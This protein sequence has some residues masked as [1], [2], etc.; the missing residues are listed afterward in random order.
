MH[1]IIYLINILIH[2]IILLF[3]LGPSM[4]LVPECGEECVNIKALI[5]ILFIL[6]N[7]SFFLYANNIKNYKFYFQ[8]I[9]CILGNFF[10]YLLLII[11]INV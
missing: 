3:F 9:L 2:S 10:I 4:N 5:G 1:I 11:I 8:I 6:L 7:I